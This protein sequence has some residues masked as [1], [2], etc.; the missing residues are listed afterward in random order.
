MDFSDGICHFRYQRLLKSRSLDPMSQRKLSS[1]E[2]KFMYLDQQIH[3]VN[4]SLDLQWRE[5]LSTRN[6]KVCWN[7][8]T[9]EIKDDLYIY[10]SMFWLREERER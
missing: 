1:V 3:E 8:E 2:A 10:K 5:H 4:Q 6:N 9:I 7:S